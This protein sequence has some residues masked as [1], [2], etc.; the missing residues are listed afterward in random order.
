M[1]NIVFDC[2]DQSVIFAEVTC[3]DGSAHEL[4]W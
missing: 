4:S 1:A 2:F 3:D